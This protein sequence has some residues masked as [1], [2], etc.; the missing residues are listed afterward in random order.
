LSVNVS[1]KEQPKRDTRAEVAPSANYQSAS[2][3]P[4]HERKR[5]DGGVGAIRPL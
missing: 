5:P 4:P 3:A 1:D 2:R